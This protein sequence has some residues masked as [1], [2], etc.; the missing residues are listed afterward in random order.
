MESPPSILPITMADRNANTKEVHVASVGT[1]M[2]PLDQRRSSSRIAVLAILV[3]VLAWIVLDNLV[4]TGA[5]RAITN[6]LIWTSHLS[7]P[8]AALVD[9]TLAIVNSTM[10]TK[11]VVK[12]ASHVDISIKKN[13]QKKKKN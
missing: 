9:G 7:R 10:L 11:L 1:L 5:L 6:T 13:K 4:V 12:L 3:P 8:F 2:A